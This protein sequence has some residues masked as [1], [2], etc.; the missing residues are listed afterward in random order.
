DVLEIGRQN[1]PKLYDLFFERPLPMVPRDLRFEVAERVDAQGNVI[2]PLAREDVQQLLPR[3]HAAGA[4]AVAVV[5]LFSYLN[6]THEQAI[7]D[8]I[9]TALNIP[10]ILSSDIFPEFREFERTSTTV[11]SAAL[12]P[13]VGDYLT[14]LE[15]GASENGLTTRWQIM[16]SNGTVTRTDYAQTNPAWILLSG[17]A[18]GVEGARVVG[19]LTGFNDLITFDMGGTSCDVSLIRDGMLSRTTEGQVGNY[20]VGLPMVD[21]HTIGAGG[22]S[23][24]WVDRGGALRVGPQSAGASPGPACYNHGGLEPT[25]T[26]AHLVLGHL[27][28]SYPV[29]ELDHL[30]IAA[31]RTAVE[32]IASSLGIT[33]EEAALG[34]LEIADAAMERAIRVISIERGYDPREFSL[35]AFGGAG[36][37]HA[38]SIAHRLAIPRVIVPAVAGVLSAFGLVAAEVGHDLSQGV[39]RPLRECEPAMIEGILSQLCERTQ[40]ELTAEGVEKGAIH[41]HVSADLRY[42]GQ[43]HELNVPLLDVSAKDT[44]PP[45]I[46][47]TFMNRI[48]SAFHAEHSRRYGHAANEEAIELVALRVRAV[49]PPTEVALTGTFRGKEQECETTKVNSWF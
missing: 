24:A 14:L 4:N 43:A 25:V 47:T 39:L 22:G 29:G 13:I 19:K 6:P 37:L 34:M 16:Q 33:A 5:F 27:L 7:G 38:V 44:E 42:L 31:A 15:G 26:D 45:A 30:D 49:G 35:L 11:V 40:T 3:L 48:V 32:E 46:D 23:I 17:P 28:A 10:V 36:P 2:R 9:A 8:S 41:F 1:R 21:I 12:R 18:A 20:P